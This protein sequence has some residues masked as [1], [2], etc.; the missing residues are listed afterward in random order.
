MTPQYISRRIAL[1]LAILLG[2]LAGAVGS[3]LGVL[4]FGY[5][6][7]VIVS[8]VALPAGPLAG[9]A[10]AYGLLGRQQLPRMP[11]MA[12]WSALS[13]PAVLLLMRVLGFRFLGHDSVTE[14]AMIGALAGSSIGASGALWQ[15]G[16]ES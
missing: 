9:C 1:A 8:L 15:R 11:P 10:A 2:G 4:A 5:A 7:G 13:L 3:L 6:V 12:A 14:E 16:T